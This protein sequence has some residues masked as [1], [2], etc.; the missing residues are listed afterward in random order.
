MGN[1]IGTVNWKSIETDEYIINKLVKLANKNYCIPI[2]ETDVE[3]NY[4]TYLG[5]DWKKFGVEG[6]R[7]RLLT[8]GRTA[9]IRVK[10]F[11]YDVEQFFATYPDI[12]YHLSFQIFPI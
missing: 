12:E 8:T 2:Y 3:S 1:F 10:S 4:L 6:K 7:N 11:L 5:P 9:T